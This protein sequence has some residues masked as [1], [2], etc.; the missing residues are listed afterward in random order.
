MKSIKKVFVSTLV[1]TALLGIFAS[2]PHASS[3]T[4]A[5][6]LNLPEP[7]SSKLER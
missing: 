2:L 7:R 1:T 3:P 5:A 4:K 6:D